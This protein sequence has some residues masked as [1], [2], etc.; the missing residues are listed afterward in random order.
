MARAIIS[1]CITAL[2]ASGASAETERM[3]LDIT[4]VEYFFCE[5]PDEDEILFAVYPRDAE[6]DDTAGFTVI[7][8]FGGASRAQRTS[9]GFYAILDLAPS[10]VLKFNEAQF[11]GVFGS[12]VGTGPCLSVTDAVQPVTSRIL[13][14]QTG[15]N[16]EQ[17]KATIEG[18]RDQIEDFREEMDST[19][20]DLARASA[21]LRAARST[22]RQSRVLL[23]EE[24]L[25]Q[26]NAQVAPC[27][28]P[29]KLGG[30][31]GDQV[32]TVG[33]RILSSGQVSGLSSHIDFLPSRDAYLTM[34]ADQ[35][36]D[37]LTECSIT[38]DDFQMP[39]DVTAVLH[40]DG[41]QGT[42]ASV[43]HDQ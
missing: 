42:V 21:R 17:L 11:I 3:P 8:S 41:D 35:V 39:N 18:L 9:D 33:V 43:T 30:D 31:A 26:L 22:L 27:W 16:V 40:F 20:A 6:T 12:E 19:K 36:E 7:N 25:S 23:G 24:H 38:L 14:S 4:D 34:A 13:E 37:A 10:E 32:V 15:E 5:D 2:L 1:A 29:E 28:S